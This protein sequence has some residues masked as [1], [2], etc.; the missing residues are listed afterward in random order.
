M[1]LVFHPRCLHVFIC[2]KIFLTTN[3]FPNKT[4]QQEMLVMINVYYY[5]PIY[6]YDYAEMVFVFG[7]YVCI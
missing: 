2:N 1:S 4:K 6:I 7:Y 5:K 3:T